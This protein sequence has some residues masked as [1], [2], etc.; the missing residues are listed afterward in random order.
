MNRKFKKQQL[1]KVAQWWKHGETGLS[2]E[3]IVLNVIA[4]ISVGDYPSDPSDFRRCVVMME[5]LP[6]IRTYF[7]RCMM[8]EN[9]TWKAYIKH[10]DELMD[11]YDEEVTNGTGKAPKLYKRMHELQGR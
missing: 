10:W 6:F 11:L 8:N 2:S 3:A 4:D 9:K 5:K 1:N 7:K